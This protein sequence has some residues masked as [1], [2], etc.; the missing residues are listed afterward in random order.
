M[1]LTYVS[2]TYLL[3]YAQVSQ[4]LLLNMFLDFVE[5]NDGKNKTKQKPNHLV[6]LVSLQNFL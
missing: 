3:Q 6:F 5:A 1:Y 4:S 2:H